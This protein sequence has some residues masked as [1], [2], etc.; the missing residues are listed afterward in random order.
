[1]DRSEF[2]K[3]FYMGDTLYVY[4]CPEASDPAYKC[5]CVLLS[6]EEYP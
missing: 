6:S 4:R 1:M 3:E 5:L 2:E